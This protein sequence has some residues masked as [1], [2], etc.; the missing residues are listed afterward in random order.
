MFC[1][2]SLLKIFGVGERLPFLVKGLFNFVKRVPDFIS[3]NSFLI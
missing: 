2:F 3:H 1:R